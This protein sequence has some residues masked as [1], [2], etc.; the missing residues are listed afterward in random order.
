MKKTLL[1][2]AFAFAGA[3]AY[4]QK[5]GAGDKTAEVSF[6]GAGL[7][8]F[9]YNAPELRFRYF[10]ADNM[11]VRARLS[12]GSTSSTDKETVNTGGTEVNVERKTGSGFNLGI[13]PGIEMHFAGTDKLSPYAG[14]SLN[15]GLG[16][17]ATIEYTNA[18]GGA[19]GAWTGVAKDNKATTK[20]GSTFGLGIT[21][22]MGADYYITD[23]VFVG[24][25]FGL[26]LFNMTSTGEGETTTKVS[27]VETKGKSATNST[28]DLFGMMP[29][30]GVRL[31]FKF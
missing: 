21:M 14:A 25:E 16:G 24:G 17:G 7:N 20:K 13:S 28:F 4:A 22:L 3:F 5:P 11:A 31:G 26:G 1:L 23:G 27:G 9:N 2:A 6:T 10:L 8:S 12:L 18:T 15:I 30:G 19:P 29:S